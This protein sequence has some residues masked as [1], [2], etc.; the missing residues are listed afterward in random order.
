MED[1]IVCQPCRGSQFIASQS[2]SVECM[3]CPSGY[4]SNDGKTQCIEVIQ[5]FSI[6]L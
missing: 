4:K 5:I 1:M 6:L 3:K 2:G